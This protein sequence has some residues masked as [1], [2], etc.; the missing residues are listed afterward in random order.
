MRTVSHPC[1]ALALVALTMSGA[2]AATTPMQ[3]S[4]QVTSPTGDLADQTFQ[5]ER[6]ETPIA[7]SL[8]SITNL[9]ADG[10]RGFLVTFTLESGQRFSLQQL[11]GQPGVV[12]PLPRA[13]L[14][15]EVSVRCDSFSQTGCRYILSLVG[16]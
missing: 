16:E 1:L 14:V 8:I 7:T 9:G 11:E 6:F 4:E 3:R 12:V 13:A 15:R 5:N 2:C 10:H